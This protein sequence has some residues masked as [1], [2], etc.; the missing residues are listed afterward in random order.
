MAVAKPTQIQASIE[1]MQQFPPILGMA[2]GLIRFAKESH[3]IAMPS[4]RQGFINVFD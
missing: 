3:W 2:G 4:Q 1:A